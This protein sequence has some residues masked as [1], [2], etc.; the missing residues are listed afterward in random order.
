M[1]VY[2]YNDGFSPQK[3]QR[4]REQFGEELTFKLYLQL[5]D[6]DINDTQIRSIYNIPKTTFW[7]WRK[8]HLDKFQ[9]FKTLKRGR[10]KV[11]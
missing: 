7:E 4:I 2:T 3:A 6:L 11:N 1:R 5:R 9:S 8:P 10:K